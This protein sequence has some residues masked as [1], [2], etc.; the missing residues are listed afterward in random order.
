ME[1]PKDDEVVV[2]SLVGIYAHIKPDVTSSIFDYSKD[3]QNNKQDIIPYNTKMIVLETQG[4][5]FYVEFVDGRK[6][7]IFN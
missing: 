6:A 2:A 5:W 1:E 4:N 7:W 3:G